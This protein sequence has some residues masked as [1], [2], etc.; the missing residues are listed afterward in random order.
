MLFILHAWA[1]YQRP[2]SL[3]SSLQRCRSWIC[4]SH[5]PSLRVTVPS[6]PI[7]T[8]STVNHGVTFLIF[9][10]CSLSELHSLPDFGITQ[11]SSHPLCT[12]SYVISPFHCFFLQCTH[13]FQSSE[14]N[15]N[16]PQ[17]EPRFDFR[18]DPQYPS[19]PSPSSLCI[20]LL[21]S[22]LQACPA[23]SIA[24][25]LFLPCQQ[26]LSLQLYDSLFVQL[27]LLFRLILMLPTFCLGMLIQGL[28][29][30]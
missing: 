7:T 21:I 22:L 18:L 16:W 5:S 6:A 24:C 15:R 26:T 20:Q 11:Y 23:C 8:G 19:T 27:L 10:S 30:Q 12:F 17:P 29:T 14:T 3:R 2:E 13:H 4:W 1:L 9:C 28:E 25:G